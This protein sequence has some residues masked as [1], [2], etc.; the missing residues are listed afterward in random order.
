MKRKRLGRPAQV[1][2]R[3]ESVRP[4]TLDPE[5]VGNRTFRGAASCRLAE[6]APGD[7]PKNTTAS[8]PRTAHLT[9]GS[10]TYEPFS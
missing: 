5:M 1:P 7:R 2:R 9:G 10:I 8:T 4:T 6:P 3:A